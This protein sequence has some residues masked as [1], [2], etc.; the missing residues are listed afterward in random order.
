MLK[1]TLTIAVAMLSFAS[2]VAAAP[3]TMRPKI[4][5]GAATKTALAIVPNGKIEA[6]E[7]E[8]EHHRLIY[9][10]DIRVPG[11]TGIDEVQIS[12]ITG[13][14]VSHTHETPKMEHAE[15]AADMKAHK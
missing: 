14:L 7:L 4:T 10:F 12:A 2:V 1:R 9:S 6:S 3:T 8:T 5:K 13:K 11:K 15:A